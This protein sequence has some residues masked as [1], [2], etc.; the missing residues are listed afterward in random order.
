MLENKLMSASGRVHTSLAE[1][2]HIK[3]A[4]RSLILI[5]ELAANLLQATNVE[6]QTGAQ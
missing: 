6:R 3:I 2:A 1:A 5:K 4:A